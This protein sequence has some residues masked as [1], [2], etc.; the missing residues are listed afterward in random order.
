[1]PVYGLTLIVSGESIVSPIMSVIGALRCTSPVAAVGVA[2]QTA[3]SSHFK[4]V[5][6]YRFKI[7]WLL[8]VLGYRQGTL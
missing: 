5:I 4:A 1:V 3:R 8:S 2:A 7:F 6:V